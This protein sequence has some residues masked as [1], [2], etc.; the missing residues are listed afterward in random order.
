MVKKNSL[1]K[2]EERTKNVPVFI[3]GSLVHND[4]VAKEVESWGIKKIKNLRSVKENS[5]VIITAHGA[6]KEVYEKIAQKGAKVFDA[7][8]PKVAL[9]HQLVKEKKQAGFQVVI[10]GDKNH[11]E[12]KGIAS[13]GGSDLKIV[14]S[15]KEAQALWKNHFF[16]KKKGRQKAKKSLAG[17]PNHPADFRV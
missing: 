9:I 2:K 6:P 4:G 7:T 1:I 17:F 16:Q 8:C 14:N 5:I 13:W 12:V 11:K 15:L 10:F 3:L